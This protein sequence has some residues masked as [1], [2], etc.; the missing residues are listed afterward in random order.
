MICDYRDLALACPARGD[1]CKRPEEERAWFGDTQG[2]ESAAEADL[3]WVP[4][5]GEAGR[6]AGSTR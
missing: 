5:P 3:S 1:R 4:R 2:E 6:Q